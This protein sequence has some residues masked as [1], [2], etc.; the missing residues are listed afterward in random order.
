M[1]VDHENGGSSGDDLP[2]GDVEAEADADESL[3]FQ[4]RSRRSPLDTYK[5]RDVPRLYT[6]LLIM[7]FIGLLMLMQFFAIFNRIIQT[8]TAIYDF[9]GTVVEQVS[10]SFDE[11]YEEDEQG[12]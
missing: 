12:F 6:F 8:V 1:T 4:Q 5:G 9:A 2:R 7:L 3:Q 11:S 10:S